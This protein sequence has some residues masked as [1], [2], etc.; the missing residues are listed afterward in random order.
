MKVVCRAQYLSEAVPNMRGV[1]YDATF[2]VHAVKGRPLKLNQYC[3]VT[4]G[5]VRRRITEANKDVA[6]AWFCEWAVPIVNA[7]SSGPKVLVP[8]PSHDALEHSPGDFR[9]AQIAQSLAAACGGNVKAAPVLRL[10]EE[11]VPSSAGGTRDPEEIYPNLVV[12]HPLPPGDVILVDDVYTTGGHLVAAAWRLEDL[13]RTPVLGVA[14][15][16]ALHFQLD[17]P[18]AVETEDCAIART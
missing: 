9:T 11:M 13:G 14:C 17:D 12:T 8:V 5:G 18:F 4:I 6:I 7:I 15:G 2:L 3:K 16:R 10:R 1:D